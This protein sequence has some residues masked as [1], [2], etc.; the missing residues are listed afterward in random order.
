MIEEDPAV[1]LK[2]P[3]RAFGVCVRG[4]PEDLINTNETM[5]DIFDLPLPAAYRLNHLIPVSYY[6]ASYMYPCGVCPLYIYISMDFRGATRQF[7]SAVFLCDTASKL[8]LSAKSEILKAV[9]LG[10]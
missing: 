3:D 8:A 9:R 1:E 6:R 7:S 10:I 5:K 4:E 2:F